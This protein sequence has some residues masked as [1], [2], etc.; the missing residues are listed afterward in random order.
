M[1]AYLERYHRANLLPHVSCL[2]ERLVY[3]HHEGLLVMSGPRWCSHIAYYGL[4]VFHYMS[5]FD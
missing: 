4:R 2:T 5:G 1:V 3:T